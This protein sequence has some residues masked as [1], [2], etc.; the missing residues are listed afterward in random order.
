MLNDYMNACGVVQSMSVRASILTGMVRYLIRNIEFLKKN[1]PFYKSVLFV[2]NAYKATPF[3][4]SAAFSEFQ[5]AV[6]DLSVR[7]NTK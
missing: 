3:E 5:K 2:S 7:M 1:E 4:D 6:S